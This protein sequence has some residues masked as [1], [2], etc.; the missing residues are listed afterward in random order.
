[1][2]PPRFC[3]SCGIKGPSLTHIG[4]CVPP[5]ENLTSSTTSAA[6]GTTPASPRLGPSC[7]P[8]D[9]VDLVVRLLEPQ[10]DPVPGGPSVTDEALRFVDDERIRALL[11]A[12]RE[13]GIARY[14]RELTAAN[15]RDA[16]ADAAQEALDLLL[17]LT[18][19]RMEGRGLI[20]WP[21]AKLLRQILDAAE[22]DPRAGRRT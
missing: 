6:A 9:V 10:P 11:Q 13:Q 19:L 12:R 16:L 15:G 14:G 21:L 20:L 3:P 1:M 2:S 4:R 22:P 5:L 7:D 18:Q 8:V 17:Y